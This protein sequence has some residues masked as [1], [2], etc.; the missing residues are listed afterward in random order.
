MVRG[1]QSPLPFAPK[2][3]APIVAPTANDRHS[4]RIAHETKFDRDETPAERGARRAPP[5]EL[6]TALRLL[7]LQDLI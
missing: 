1:H 6:A 4:A 5:R 3:L 7:V 2:S